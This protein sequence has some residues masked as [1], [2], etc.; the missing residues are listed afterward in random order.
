ME[1]YSLPSAADE[2]S[3]RSWASHR[4]DGPPRQVICGLAPCGWLLGGETNW[5]GELFS[6][7]SP[8]WGSA[9]GQALDRLLQRYCCVHERP[10]GVQHQHAAGEG[11]GD[12]AGDVEDCAAAWH[13]GSRENAELW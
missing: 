10:P 6:S 7:V 11:G 3:Q 5:R 8:V 2:Q 13:L 1:A 9:R 4:A 12:S